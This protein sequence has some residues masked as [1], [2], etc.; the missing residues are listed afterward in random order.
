[1]SSEQGIRYKIF[2]EDDIEAIIMPPAHLIK[3]AP[4]QN[5]AASNPQLNAGIQENDFIS[6]V[7]SFIAR[8]NPGLVILTPCYNSTVF[9]TYMESLIQTFSMCREIGLR[10]KVH[11]CKNDSLVSRARNNLIAKAMTDP[12]TTH[13]LFIDADITWDPIDIVKLLLAEK[14]VVGGIYPIK[15]YNWSNL[16]S[17]PNFVKNI[18]NK[19]N[20]SQ[21]KDMVSDTEFLKTN[22]VKYNVNYESTVLNVTNNLAKVK[23]LATG[24]MMIK[25]EVIET[26]MKGFPDTKYVDDVGFL[27]GKENDYAYALFDC[28]V[29]EGHYFSE[30]WMFCHR[31]TKMGGGVYI[32]VTINLDHTGIEIYKGSYISSVL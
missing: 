26:M 25:R 22:M 4:I 16:S 1:M 30:D 29:E 2:E 5:L 24:F 10:M 17:D 21:L 3:V 32:D 20:N 19:K 9:V 11:F 27:Y 7:K 14:G 23:H 6:K 31:W 28:G 8:N 13:M 12:E 18:I 15:S